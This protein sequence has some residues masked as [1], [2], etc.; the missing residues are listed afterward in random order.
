MGDA[1]ANSGAMVES[2]PTKTSLLDP[3]TKYA[4]VAATNAHSAVAAGMPARREVA[5]CSGT[6]ITR[7][8]IPANTSLEIQERW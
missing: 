6:A 5:S 8:V 7:R 3:N 4:I 2:A 1:A